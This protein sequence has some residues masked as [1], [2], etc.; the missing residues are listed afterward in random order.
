MLTIA[1]S[2]GLILLFAHHGVR[3]NALRISTGQAEP[4]EIAMANPDH[5]IILAKRQSRLALYAGKVGVSP[6]KVIAFEPAPASLMPGDPPGVVTM[7]QTGPKITR[8]S[9][10]GHKTGTVGVPQNCLLDISRSLIHGGSVGLV[11]GRQ[12]VRII[13]IGQAQIN[14]RTEG[15]VLRLIWSVGCIW[16]I[17]RDPSAIQLVPLM[18][19]TLRPITLPDHVYVIDVAFSRSDGVVLAKVGG[20]KHPPV[21]LHLAMREAKIASRYRISRREVFVIK[22]G[23]VGDEVW[24]ADS[25]RSRLERFALDTWRPQGTIE[26]KSRAAHSGSASFVV[27]RRAFSRYFLSSL[28]RPITGSNAA[29][30]GFNLPALPRRVVVRY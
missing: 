1:S 18:S 29:V 9:D 30:F 5:V 20:R 4:T 25:M 6:A 8:L 3:P 13:R 11:C 28:I 2:V 15:R 12:D 27:F 7:G 21:L 19:S 26:F 16:A 23:I 24:L 17:E 14:L 22:I 10:D